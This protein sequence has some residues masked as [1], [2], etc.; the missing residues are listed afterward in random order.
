MVSNYSGGDELDKE[1]KFIL[2]KL[3]SDSLTPAEVIAQELG[4]S[5]SSVQRRIRRLRDEKIISR[6][7]AVVDPKK[8]G[9]PLVFVA[10][11]EI[12]RERKELL[13][14]LRRW[15]NREEAVQQAF[16]VT[17]AT[18]LVLIVLA[19]DIEDYDSI[20]QRLVEDNS[21]V[22]RVTT[23]VALQ[24]YKQSLSVPIGED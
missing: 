2:A 24:I 16:Y 3:Q 12:E 20:T 1:D 21:N 22:R 5:A 9:N 23:S 13:I 15:L 11:L 18:D 4:L 8:V 14:Q 17:G 10:S 6:H 7:C 19:K